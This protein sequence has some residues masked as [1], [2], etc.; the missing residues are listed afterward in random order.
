MVAAK[1]FLTNGANYA[2]K[3]V[4]YLATPKTVFSPLFKK[5]WNGQ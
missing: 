1:S 3:V 4:E 5:L 2:Q